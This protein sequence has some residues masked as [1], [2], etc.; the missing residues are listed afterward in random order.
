MP[1]GFTIEQ[2]KDDNRQKVVTESVLIERELSGT[3]SNS[4]ELF[5]KVEEEAEEAYEQSS[6]EGAYETMQVR[7][8]V[9]PM[10]MLLDDP[11]IRARIE[12]G[13]YGAIIGEDASG[14]IPALIAW[15]VVNEIYR[16]SKKPSVIAHFLHPA[17]GHRKYETFNYEEILRFLSDVKDSLGKRVL[18]VTEYVETGQSVLTVYKALRAL[19]L[20]MDLFS[21]CGQPMAFASD[22]LF[23]P[24]KKVFGIISKEKVPAIWG[25]RSLSG[26]GDPKAGSA[27]SLPHRVSPENIAMTRRDVKRAV[28]ELMQMYQSKYAKEKIN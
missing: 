6:A 22:S 7:E 26:V 14:R 2:R 11:E 1:E 10:K 5:Q 19:G 3:E 23:K 8:L 25:E 18:Y 9:E 28:K 12:N 16:R 15:R 4:N 24:F 20:E 27:F 17:R 21:V 13:K